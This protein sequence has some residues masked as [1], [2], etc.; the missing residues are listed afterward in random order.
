MEPSPPAV[1]AAKALISLA[2]RDKRAASEAFAQLDFEHQLQVICESPLVSRMRMLDLAPHPETLIPLIPEAEFCFTV[3][4]VGLND[5]SWLLEYAT[6]E[7]LIA[8]SDLDAWKGNTPDTATFG[9]WLAIMAEAGDETLI[10]AA[11]AIDPELWV[12]FL[13]TDVFIDL[14]PGNDE[15]WQPP[16][17]ARTLDGQFY[18]TAKRSN[19]DTEAI[20]TLLRVVFQ[21]DY[22]L[23]FR[24]L[25]GVM[26]ETKSDLEEWAARWRSGR[27]QDLGFPTW[28]E[29]MQIY[30]HIRPDQ[31]ANLPDE[32]QAV[33]LGDVRLPVWVPQ[34]PTAADTKHAIFRVAGE[35]D[36]NERRSFYFGFIALA[37][38]V[39]VADSMVLGDTDTL[40]EAIDKTA[41]IASA[42]LEFIA[43]ETGVALA[44][45]LRRSRVEQL[46]R[47][48]ANLDRVAA[49]RN[50]P[51]PFTKI[52]GD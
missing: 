8:C 23:Y 36:A 46:F 3:K 29:A 7:Q 45:V 31:R 48:G 39:A 38:R 17:G 6:S 13:R 40:P 51:E 21:E 26:W 5:A 30:G 1:V 27:L 9:E 32:T 42:G 14:K 49:S 28:D 50:R 10:R 19:D 41:E 2:R 18:F 11:H 33:D 24:L 12:L 35:L 25:Q 47:V 37:N 4:S 52:V 16:E 20:A 44:D 43:G 34:L 22:W 15:G